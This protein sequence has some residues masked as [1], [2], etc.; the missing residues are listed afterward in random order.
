MFEVGD[1]EVHREVHVDFVVVWPGAITGRDGKRLDGAPYAMGRP[2][3][4]GDMEQHR[5]YTLGETESVWRQA[6]F[7]RRRVGGLYDGTAREA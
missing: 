2:G 7:I 6:V 3:P 4:T 1:P 5:Q